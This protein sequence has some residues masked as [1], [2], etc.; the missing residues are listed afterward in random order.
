MKMSKY[1]VMFAVTVGVASA[2]T[3]NIQ[4]SQGANQATNFQNAN[5]TVSN[6]LVWGLM[7]TTGDS[8]FSALPGDYVLSTSLNGKLIPGTDDYFIASSSL[9]IQGSAADAANP[10]KI[11]SILGVV[12]NV[13]A[14]NPIVAGTKFAV[15]WFDT[16]VA[17]NAATLVG[18][19]Q[20]GLLTNPLMVVPADGGTTNVSALFSTNPDP[21]KPANQFTVTGIPEPSAALLGALGVLG[22]LRR[23]RI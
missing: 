7:F 5:G 12:S 3:V 15:V 14:T 8:T 22:L 18:G 6:G 23:R 17:S 9:T 13:P 20:Y 11:V 4:I 10:G 2:A 16:A 19:Q 21:A 1:I